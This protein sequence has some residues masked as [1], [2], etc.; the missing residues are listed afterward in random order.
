MTQTLFEEVIRTEGLLPEIEVAQA[1]HLVG[2]RPFEHTH[3]GDFAVPCT[4]TG[5][6]AHDFPDIF[7]RRVQHARSPYLVGR[8]GLPPLGAVVFL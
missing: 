8:P 1:R 4:H 7:N 3:A 2:P 6:I 5:E